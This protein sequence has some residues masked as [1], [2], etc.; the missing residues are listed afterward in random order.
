MKGLV[1]ETDIEELESLH[2]TTG[3]AP[4][5]LL[6]PYADQSALQALAMHNYVLDGFLNIYARSL[7]DIQIEVDPY[8]NFS[9]GPTFTSDVVVS[10]SPA[11]DEI[12][13]TFIRASV[14]GF[15]YDGR[16]LDVL[17]TYAEAAV[18]RRDTIL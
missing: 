9:E 12:A 15:K 3:L 16:P 13:S 14:A 11:N 18:L 5:I 8:M 2:T 6:C 1:A 17:E 10:R 4:S 7:K